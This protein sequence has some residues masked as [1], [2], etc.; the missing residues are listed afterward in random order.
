MQVVYRNGTLFFSFILYIVFLQ[1]GTGIELRVVT[2]AR[3]STPVNVIRLL[4]CLISDHSLLPIT[5][6]LSSALQTHTE[7]WSPEGE[8][9]Q[10]L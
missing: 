10:S 3:R 4:V 2:P 5:T 9:G 6:H 7:N 8:S 1:E